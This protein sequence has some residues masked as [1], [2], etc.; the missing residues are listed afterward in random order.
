MKSNQCQ[1]CGMPIGK[2][3]LEGTEK[4]G[5]K[6]IKYCEH[7]YQNGEW[8]QNLNFD[9][10]YAYNLKRFQESDINKVQ[11]YF[12][13]KMYTKKFMKKLERWK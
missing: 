6:S 7:C 4:N 13:N 3:T 5:T 11:K 9:E 2:G 8:T 10:M 1:S 12:L